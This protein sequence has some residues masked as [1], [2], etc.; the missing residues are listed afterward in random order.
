MRVAIVLL[1]DISWMIEEQ[2][3]GTG[4]V[5]KEL[6]IDVCMFIVLCVLCFICGVIGYVFGRK[7][8]EMERD[9]GK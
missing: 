9:C 5:V 6:I 3:G 7:K 2:Q 4:M 8:S 1:A